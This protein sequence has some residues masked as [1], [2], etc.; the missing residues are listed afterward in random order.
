MPSPG[1]VWVIDTSSITEVRRSF[2]KPE[3]RLVYAR[4]KGLVTGGHLVFP[5][6]VLK[7]LERAGN[8]KALADDLPLGWCK[9][10]APTA[11]SNPSLDTVKGVLAR[12]REVL[13]PDKP[14]GAEEADPYIL[15][16]A[17]ELQGDGRPVTIITEDKTNKPRK[18]SLS[19]A[20]GL[21]LIPAV[22]MLPFLKS[23]GLLP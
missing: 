10:V 8:P 14:R 15:A 18:L 11:V 12:V 3:Q 13:D 7:E 16:R 5:V 4:L 19:T 22:T 6:E 23:Q 2:P 9:D 1:E 17:V 21:L 20:A